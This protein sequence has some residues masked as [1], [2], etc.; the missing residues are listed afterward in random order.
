[1]SQQERDGFALMW[2]WVSRIQGA[3]NQLLGRTHAEE[4]ALQSREH[5]FLYE[6]TVKGAELTE[7]VIAASTAM[8]QFGGSRVINQAIARRLL[9]PRMTKTLPDQD[10]REC[11]GV[12]PVPLA[13]LLTRIAAFLLK[14]PNQ[15]TRL[16]AVR[17]Y[18]DKHGQ[19]I[20]DAAIEKGLAGVKTEYRG[21]PVNGQPTDQ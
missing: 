5:Q 18:F 10:L 2:R 12:A 14:I 13:E 15:L 4:F 21:T 11:L 6:P 8:G 1:V 17:R 20:L 9:A 3:N 19:T 16:K 7:N